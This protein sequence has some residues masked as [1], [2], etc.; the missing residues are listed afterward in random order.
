MSVRAIPS[1]DERDKDV[2]N[3]IRYA[4]DNGAQIISMSF[5]KDFSP[6]KAV[7]DAAMQYADQKGVLLVHAA[8][9]SGLDTDTGRNF[10]ASRYLSGQD[11][12][13]LITVGASSR[14]NNQELPA[15]FSNY[16]KQT[17][18]LFAP[19]VNI[20]SATPANQYATYSGTSMAGPVVAGVA[21]VLKS[22][23][24]QLTAAQ[25]KQVILQSA[26]P[27]HTRVLKPGSKKTVDFAT[28]SRT[29]GIVNLYEALKL[30]QQI[31]T[32]K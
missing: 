22:Y 23:Y 9:N 32:A 17:V 30:A 7:V 11:I 12:P 28:L 26:V 29:G 18:D 16:G 25:L 2:A 13:N 21:A 14:N 4:V 5:G 10:P 8:G 31:T 27:Y 24:P 6:E 3:A 15:D 20:Y 1:G 19:G